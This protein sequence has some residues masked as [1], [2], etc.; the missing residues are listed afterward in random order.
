M[1]GFPMNRFAP[2]GSVGVYGSQIHHSVWTVWFSRVPTSSTLQPL[3]SPTTLTGLDS[4]VSPLPP[5]KSI[6]H[7]LSIRRVDEYSIIT[8]MWLVLAVRHASGVLSATCAFVGKGDFQVPTSLFD[9]FWIT[10]ITFALH[11]VLFCPP[12]L[13]FTLLT[14]HA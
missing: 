5:R 8:R 2:S 9:A 3:A 12:G 1:L 14:T 10:C 13:H 6:R 4:R 7:Y 11:S